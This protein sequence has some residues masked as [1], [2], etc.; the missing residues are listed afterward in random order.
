MIFQS[1]L[2]P[3]IIKQKSNGKFHGSFIK[4]CQRLAFMVNTCCTEFCYSS[5]T[6]IDTEIDK[7]L[8][9]VFQFIMRH[10]RV[11]HVITLARTHLRH[12]KNTHVV[13]RTPKKFYGAF[14]FAQDS[15]TFYTCN[16]TFYCC[17][18]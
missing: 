10:G 15:F 13:C 4:C 8:H 5:K 3:A 7:L 1:D 17:T 11:K 18:H 2:L 12:I 6:V 9:H 16:Y 14:P